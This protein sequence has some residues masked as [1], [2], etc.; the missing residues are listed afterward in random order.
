VSR[1]HR[2][3]ERSEVVRCRPGIVPGRGGPGSAAHRSASLHAALRPGHVLE[4]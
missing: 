4:L 1:A 3:T 2:S